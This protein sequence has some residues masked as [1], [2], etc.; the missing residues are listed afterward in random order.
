MQTL[1]TNIK[2]REIL[3]YSTH[4]QSRDIKYWSSR[5]LCSQ[6]ST[7]F[8]VYKC[9][10][11][12]DRILQTRKSQATDCQN[13]GAKSVVQWTRD[14]M[15]KLSEDLSLPSKRLHLKQVYIRFVFVMF[16]CFSYL[17]KS[18]I[19]QNH[20]EHSIE[21]LAQGRIHYQTRRQRRHP[22]L[23]YGFAY[24]VFPGLSL[25]DTA[26]DLHG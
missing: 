6:S 8:S 1:N 10:I 9:S 7:I 12:Q 11:R 22:S 14:K 4:F 16:H 25:C 23:Q 5:S 24:L 19:Q 20:K 15:L 26:W 17:S 3:F 13:H 2:W 18:D 21:N